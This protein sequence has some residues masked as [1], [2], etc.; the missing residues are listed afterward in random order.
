ME[1]TAGA[2]SGVVTVPAGVIYWDEAMDY[3]GTTQTLMGPIIT[4]DA[5]GADELYSLGIA[6]PAGPP[7]VTVQCAGIA[8]G[9]VVG[10]EIEVTGEI[11]L[12]GP[13]SNPTIV[14]T[15]CAQIEY[16]TCCGYFKDPDPGEC[17]PGVVIPPGMW[18]VDLVGPIDWAADVAVQIGY[19][20]PDSCYFYPFAEVVQDVAVYDLGAVRVMMSSVDPVMVPLGHY[21]AMRVDNTGVTD[22]IIDCNGSLSTMSSPEGDPGYPVP[23]ISAGILMALGL[24]GLG[25]YAYMRRKAVRES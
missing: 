23:E 18:P 12:F 20:D 1:R 3:L 25:F 5:F 4:V 17:D 11:N 22:Q 19:S 21:L 16:A 14:V 9:Y 6:G 13:F 10:E 8:C 2:Q 7:C 24:G 15:D